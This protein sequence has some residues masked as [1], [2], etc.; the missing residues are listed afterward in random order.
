MFE[1][2]TDGARSAVNDAQKQARALNDHHI[3]P[4]HLLLALLD[5]DDATAH[6]LR[7]AG[8]DLA[9]LRARAVRHRHAAGDFLDPEAL[10]VI[11]ID[12]DAVR[13]ATEGTFGAG[14]LDVPA[15]RLRRG[16]KGRPGRRA[17]GHIPFD[18]RAKKSLEMSLR[19]AL[20]LKQRHIATGHVLLGVLH[21]EHSAAARLAAEA[22][23][24]LRALRATITRLLTAE[25]A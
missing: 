3:G 10:R 23:A 9:D 16:P 15:E 8:L 1:R 24:D 4:E 18:P 13:E 5:G 22:G 11:G 25:A 12:L 6:A 17:N 14:A 2:F 7:G 19:H 20:R 21:D